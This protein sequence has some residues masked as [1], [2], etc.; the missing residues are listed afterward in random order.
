MAQHDVLADGED[1]HDPR[2]RKQPVHQVHHVAEEE[3]RRR[4]TGGE[5]G[6][7]L[8]PQASRHTDV[9]VQAAFGVDGFADQPLLYHVIGGQ[10]QRH[11]AVG[12]VDEEARAALFYSVIE[13]F[14]VG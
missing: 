1:L 3:V 14:G 4:R 6:A 10:V 12:V 2:R 5:L 11:G 13:R 7:A 9:V 8:A